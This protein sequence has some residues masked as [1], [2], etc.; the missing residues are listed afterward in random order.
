MKKT[1]LSLL[2]FSL[3]ATISV[4]QGVFKITDPNNGNIVV[5]STTIDYWGAPNSMMEAKL[6]VKNTTNS[7]IDVFCK[8][9]T[10]ST[11]SGSTNLFCWVLCYGPST[12]QSPTGIVLAADST[13]SSFYGKYT[14]GPGTG[15]T[16]IRYV[17]FGQYNPSDSSYVTVNYHVTPTGIATYTLGKNALSPAFPNPTAN[18]VSLSYSLESDATVA[19]II[20]YNMLGEKIKELP[21]DINNR[22]GIVKADVT[23]MDAGI[24]FYSFVVNGKTIATKKL[25]VTH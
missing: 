16:T 21:I 19:K 14:T 18:L 1:L 13:T 5:N 23:G 17:F 8:R 4:A 22:E 10:I 6:N 24:Y 2:S 7:S 15:V 20:F 3:I 11:V 12:N 25:V 9:D